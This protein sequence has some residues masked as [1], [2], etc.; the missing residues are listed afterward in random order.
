MEP[1]VGTG[2]ISDSEERGVD[3]GLPLPLPVNESEKV[4]GDP[5]STG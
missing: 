1:S 4:R 2:R 5:L 3:G